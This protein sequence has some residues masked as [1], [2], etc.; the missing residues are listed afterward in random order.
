MRRGRHACE[1]GWRDLLQEVVGTFESVV[2]GCIANLLLTAKLLLCVLHKQSILS[3]Q[4]NAHM[5]V[6]IYVK[7]LRKLSISACVY[8]VTNIQYESSVING[9][10]E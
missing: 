9:L 8:V 7:S 4:Y 1:R 6:C 5:A 10:G 3:G 2:N